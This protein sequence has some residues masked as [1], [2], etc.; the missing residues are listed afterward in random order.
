MCGIAGYVTWAGLTGGDGAV[1]DRMTGTL[2]HR[3]PDG[4][5]QWI[6]AHAAIGHTRLSV[7]DVDSGAQPMVMRGRNGAALVISYNGELYNYRKLRAQLQGLGRVFRTASD[8]EVVLQAFDEWGAGCVERF[9]GMFAFAV[10]DEHAR[11]LTL[12]RDPLGVKPLF[13]VHTP[14]HVVFGSEEKAILAHPEVEPVLDAAGLAELFCLVPMVNRE[15]TVLRGFHQVEPGHIVTFRHG[16][17]RSRCYWRLEARP[18]RDDVPTTAERI[19]ELLQESVRGQLISDVPLGTMLSGGVD[20]SAVAALAAQD[21]PG[22]KTYDIDYTSTR[23]NYSASALQIDRDSPWAVKMAAHIGSAH[24]T[25]EVSTDE[26]LAAQDHALR[27]WGRPMHRSLSVSMYLLFQ[28]IRDSGTIV[29]VGGEGADEAFAGYPWW[30]DTPVG[31]F[32]WHRTYQESTPLLRRD[33]VWEAELTDYARDSYATA[34]NRIPR[35]DSDTP[36]DRRAREV[37]WL[38]YTFYLDFLLQR[39][40]RMSMAASVEARVPFC[41]HD[42][43]Q[44]AWNI[45]WAM[46]NHGGI[47]KGILRAAVGDLLPA[48]VAMR[49]KSGYPSA[50]TADY[51]RAQ[52]GAARDVLADHGAPVWQVVDRS[53]VERIIA[54]DDNGADWTALNRIAYVLETNMWLTDLRVRIA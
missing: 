2:R 21:V 41:D 4:A 34:R 14:D 7:I 49:R 42:L 30:R 29:V 28:H 39:V 33:V 25:R 19:R 9:T 24:S 22:L 5:G 17:V 23:T 48:D 1:L 20:S 36:A 12:A 16:I 6:G 27:I 50:Q 51:Q 38:T 10:W 18:H 43:A 37:S 54:D 32:P 52:F 45:P 26:L 15:R 13:Y 8:T 31:V 44:Y 11:T 53:V 47:E 3:G 35:L 46:K 40:D